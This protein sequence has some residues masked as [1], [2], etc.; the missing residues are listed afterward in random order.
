MDRH[1][2]LSKASVGP[3]YRFVFGGPQPGQPSVQRRCTRQVVDNRYHLPVDYGGFKT[4]RLV[5]AENQ[6][7]AKYLARDLITNDPRLKT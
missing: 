7:R 2:R 1:K 6:K 5:E 4:T 3:N